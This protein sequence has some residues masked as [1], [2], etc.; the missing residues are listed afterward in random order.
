MKKT[1]IKRRKR[2]VP[3]H[4]QSESATPQPT[5]PVGASPSSNSPSP[6]PHHAHSPQI[7]PYGPLPPLWASQHQTSRI[8]KSYS[9]E[10]TDFTT[11]QPYQHPSPSF[12]SSYNE[13]NTLPPLRLPVGLNPQPMSPPTA[14]IQHVGG[15]I[16][17]PKRKLDSPESASK[18]I[19]TVGLLLN[20]ATQL[21]DVDPL[22]G[23]RMLLSLGSRESVIRKRAQL[24]GEIEVMAEKME[25]LKRAVG[26]C[27]EFLG[28]A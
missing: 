18:R 17:L 11:Y 3:T 6:P 14:M 8:S 22:E 16:P 26:E 2:I 7:N 27:D 1:V 4:R 15:A 25:K 28:K 20:S 21:E 9:P 24:M 5:H 10:P 19:R 13:T 12:P 23:A